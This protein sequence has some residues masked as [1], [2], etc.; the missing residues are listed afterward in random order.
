MGDDRGAFGVVSSMHGPELD[1][2]AWPRGER[3]GALEAVGVRCEGVRAAPG[4]LAA[5]A[6]IAGRARTVLDAV[7]TRASRRA[8]R[9]DAPSG[10]RRWSLDARSSALADRRMARRQS[11]VP[12]GER[13]VG[14]RGVGSEGMSPSGPAAATVVG[15]LLH[16]HGPRRTV[17]DRLP[18][19]R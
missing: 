9:P 13:E 12:D 7:T 17:A 2:V 4:I 3:P 19:G 5:G 15:A 8:P 1:V 14:S 6:T 11:L 10:V 16:E 18:A